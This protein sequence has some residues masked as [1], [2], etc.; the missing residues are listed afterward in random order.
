MSTFYMVFSVLAVLLAF[1]VGRKRSK[2]VRVAHEVIHELEVGDIVLYVNPGVQ[3]NLNNMITKVMEVFPSHGTVLIHGRG[4]SL[5]GST[6]CVVSARHLHLLPIDENYPIQVP[7]EPLIP[8]QR[9]LTPGALYNNAATWKLIPLSWFTYQIRAP[10]KQ[11]A[12]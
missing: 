6:T 11:Q 10:K 3:C 1:H 7:G 5:N 2:V 8:H 12:S 9:H 4:D